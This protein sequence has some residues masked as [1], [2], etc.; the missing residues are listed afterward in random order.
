MAVTR[1]NALKRAAAAAI[2]FG[3]P[4]LWP[5]PAWAFGAD[6]R[7]GLELYTVNNAMKLDFDGTLHR[8]AA[9]GYKSVE[10][11]WFYGH[12]ARAV[13]KSL[14]ATGLSCKS[15]LFYPNAAIERSIA[16]GEKNL[17]DDLPQLIEAA[18]IIGLE[19][20]GAVLFPMRPDEDG[21]RL[22]QGDFRRGAE[23]L[24]RVGEASKK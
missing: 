6:P 4:S 9:L 24:N 10:F 5:L 3:G 8:V 13:R 21:R 22:R 1:R 11:P 15:A 17:E 2:A 7:V 14:D 19:Y 12:S 18:T 16:P 23:F 20:M